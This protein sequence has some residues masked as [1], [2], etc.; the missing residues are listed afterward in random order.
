MS[1]GEF[2][3]EAVYEFPDILPGQ[4]LLGGELDLEMLLDGHD[5]LDMGQRIPAL[6]VVSGGSRLKHDFFIVE[7]VAEDLL[8]LF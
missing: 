4:D 8:D 2:R 6:H 7:D 3:S 1:S 5:K